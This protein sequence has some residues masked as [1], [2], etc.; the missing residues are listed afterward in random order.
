MELT[1]PSKEVLES[2]TRLKHDSYLMA[3]L[4]ANR[5]RSRTETVLQQDG[6]LLR[7]AQGRAQVIDELI[8]FIQYEPRA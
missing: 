5:E 2:L 7:Q 1:R 6:N 3:W 8:S 4:A